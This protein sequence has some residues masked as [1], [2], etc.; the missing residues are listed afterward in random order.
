MCRLLA[1]R[2]SRAAF[3]A[4]AILLL[5]GACADQPAGDRCGPC[6]AGSLCGADDTCHLLC[7]R[8]RDCATCYAC[9]DGLCHFDPECNASD[10][11]RVCTPG[12]EVCLANQCVQSCVTTADCP[13][14]EECVALGEVHYCAEPSSVR[15]V[16]GT[17]GV[18]ESAGTTLRVRGAL[19][20]H[21]GAATS[22]TYRLYPAVD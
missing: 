12:L 9:I 14:G 10:P 21:G 2:A 7:N 6:P 22:A 18:Q 19:L 17:W 4:G 1:H 13:A 3:A 15:A 16:D 11:C 8:S 5:A 20:P